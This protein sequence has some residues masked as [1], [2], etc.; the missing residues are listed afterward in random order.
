MCAAV[1][2]P[3]PVTARGGLKR[4]A[5]APPRS[6]SRPRGTRLD[7]RI[8]VEIGDAGDAGEVEPSRSFASLRDSIWATADPPLAPRAQAQARPSNMPAPRQSILA[9]PSPDPRCRRRPPTCAPPAAR[10]QAEHR[11]SMASRRAGDGPSPASRMNSR[12]RQ[13]RLGT[14]SSRARS[15]AWKSCCSPGLASMPARPMGPRAT[16]RARRRPGISTFK[17]TTVTLPSPRCRRAVRSSA[18][19]SG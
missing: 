8:L 18:A 16:G 9:T 4:Q 15:A 7:K 10:S 6:F 5:A 19:R 1:Q 12:S 13:V 2:R 14:K 3:S 17:S 11:L